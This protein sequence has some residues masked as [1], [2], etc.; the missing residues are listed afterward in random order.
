MRKTVLWLLSVLLMVPMLSCNNVGEKSPEKMDWWREA[1]FG[2]F[3]HWGLYSIPAGEWGG[4]T[5]HAEW[6]RETARIPLEQ[7]D[8]LLMQFNPQKFN[9][10]EWVALASEAGMKYIVITSKHHDGFALFDSKVS[11]FDV[12]ATPFKRDILKELSD[13][14]AHAGIKLCFY[15]SIMDWHHPDYLPRRSW[16]ENRS[17]EGADLNRYITYMKGQLTELL[18]QYG[19]I[20]VMWF[21]GEWEKTWTHEMAADLYSFLMQQDS[22]LIVNNRIDKGR[23][24]MAGLNREGEY[25]GDFGTP[26]QEIPATGLQGIDWESCITMNDHW[27]YNKNDNNWKSSEDLVR[28]LIDIAS[29]G[30]NLLLNVGPTAEGLFPEQSVERLKAIGSWMKVNGESV[31]GTESSPFASLP[32]GRCTRKSE[33]GKTLLYLHIFTMPADAKLLIPDLDNK[34]VKAYALNDPRKAKLPV[35]REGGS[36]MI[37]TEKVKESDFA[38]VLVLELKGEPKLVT[39]P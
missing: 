20:G 28:K 29:K 39:Q 35:S 16:E 36:I 27:G 7:Y 18:T 15:H 14:C 8:S 4:S 24:G 37:G 34:I 30:G 6:I 17:S 1:R 26:E 10:E 13:A 32:W 33:N 3:I 21:D 23:Q 31:Y 25:Y 12:M 2:L 38:T 11:D 5:N 9:A 22:M 19:D